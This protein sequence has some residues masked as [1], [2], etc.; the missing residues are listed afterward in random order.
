MEFSGNILLEKFPGKGGWTYAKIPVCF[1]KSSRPFGWQIVSGTI[2]DLSFEYVKLMPIGNETL[3]LA[4]KAAWRKALKKEAGD[5]VHIYLK[6]HEPSLDLPQEV[7]ACFELEPG[8]KEQFDK[9]PE[10]ERLF[11]LD[12]IRGAKSETERETRL[13]ELMNRFR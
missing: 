11:L 3:F 12:Q 10:M 8:S 7:H 6:V 1:E 2:D 13:V 5:V 4:V 9:L